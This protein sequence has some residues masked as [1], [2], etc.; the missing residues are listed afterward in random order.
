[1]LK[2][3]SARKYFIALFGAI[4][5]GAVTQLAHL[6]LQRQTTVL[7]CNVRHPLS[8]AR[9]SHFP[10][11]HALVSSAPR[12]GS[13]CEAGVKLPMNYHALPNRL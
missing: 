3:V 9:R 7:L 5:Y 4:F 13:R 2:K 11:F 10:F 8:D 1:M 6:T 12:L